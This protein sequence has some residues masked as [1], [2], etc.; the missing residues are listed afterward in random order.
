M[1]DTQYCR[2]LSISPHFPTASG[3]YF[4]KFTDRGTFTTAPVESL[5]DTCS[6]VKDLPRWE[7]SVKLMLTPQSPEVKL[8][9]LLKLTYTILDKIQVTSNQSGSSTTFGGTWTNKVIVWRRF[10][11]ICDICSDNETKTTTI[12]N[13]LKP[14]IYIYICTQPKSLK[15][16]PSTLHGSWIITLMATD[17]SCCHT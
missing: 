4:S 8:G 16:Q 13:V 12:R 7:G 10:Q 14:Y 15:P 5:S 17:P 9:E 2:C 11:Q 1:S 3:K 6:D